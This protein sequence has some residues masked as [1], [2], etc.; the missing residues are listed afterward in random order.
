[1]YFTDVSIFFASDYLEDRFSLVVEFG[2]D[3][4]A[5]IVIALVLMKDSMDMKTYGY[6]DGTD[7]SISSANQLLPQPQL[8]N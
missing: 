5:N 2:S 6:E 4:P 3:M 1:M 8:K 7:W